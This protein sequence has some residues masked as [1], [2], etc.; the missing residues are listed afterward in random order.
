M[1][2]INR[3][4]ESFKRV[5]RPGIGQ[6]GTYS[7]RPITFRNECS[8]TEIREQI[9]PR[10]SIVVPSFNQGQFIG[11][12]LQSILD[13]QYPNL[14]LI[15]VDGGSTDDTLSVINQFEDYLD[16][17]VSEPDSGQ[18][19]AINRGFMQST[20][21]IMAWINSDD[22]VASGAFYQIANYFIKH[23]DTQVIYGNRILINEIG[24]EIGRWILPFHS[25]RVLKYSDFV[26]QETLYWTRKAWYVIGGRLDET[27]QFAMDWDFLLR[28]SRNRLK[29]KHLP[30]FLGLFRVH[31]QQKTSSQMT[32]TGQN[33]MKRLRYRELG[34]QPTRWQLVTSI[35][36]FLLIAKL[37]EFYNTSCLKKGVQG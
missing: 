30:I 20:G 12:T 35:V 21:E 36:P 17:W 18:T 8:N 22:L 32:L 11:A 24:L 2:E 6:L 16:W 3:F 26:P 25:G 23:P 28:L 33:E 1:I 15:V 19:A 5:L 9:L 10:I 31:S 14:E 7:P 4:L 13:Q 27:F 29:I 37:N 34:F